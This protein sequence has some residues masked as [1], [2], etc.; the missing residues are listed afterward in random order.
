MEAITPV[1]A[2]RL[3]LRLGP[4]VELTGDSELAALG[5]DDAAINAAIN[6]AI[7]ACLEGQDYSI[8]LDRLDQVRT[9]ADF[10]HEVRMALLLGASR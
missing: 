1:E 9:V 8:L 4:E 2:L 3:V 6:A 7:L 5:A 10:E